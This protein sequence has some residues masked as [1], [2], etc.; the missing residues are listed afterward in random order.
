MSF[1]GQGSERHIQRARKIRAVV[2]ARRGGP[3]DDS[4][5]DSVAGKG[6]TMMLVQR[7][8]YVWQVAGGRWLH[9]NKSEFINI[10]IIAT[11]QR[12]QVGPTA[13]IYGP[14]EQRLRSSEYIL[15]GYTKHDFKGPV[16]GRTHM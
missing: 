6:Q 7:Q 4:E 2:L 13:N 14:N 5:R 12:L 8:D 15:T 11:R 3:G 1:E 9:V 10:K 16:M